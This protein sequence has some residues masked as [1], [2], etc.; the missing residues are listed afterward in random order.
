MGHCKL[1]GSQDIRQYTEVE[2]VRYKETVLQV[3]MDY[4]VCAECGREFVATEQ[5]R[6]NDAAARDAKR[7]HDGLLTGSE[8][9]RLRSGLKLNQE[10]AALLFGG[11]R[12]AFSK[13]ERGEVTQSASMDRLLRLCYRHPELVDDLKALSHRS[14]A[15]RMRVI[16]QQVEGERANADTWE[17]HSYDAVVANRDFPRYR[18]K[19][20][21]VEELHYG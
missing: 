21:A 3:P 11:G 4:S 9:V 15:F 20:L 18:I 16:G 19:T 17:T 14:P 2:P 10:M 6:R 5:I 12:N 1:C 8:I 7:T 13:Y